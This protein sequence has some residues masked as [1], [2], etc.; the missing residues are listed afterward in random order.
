MLDQL[1]SD[2]APRER[3][4]FYRQRKLSQ[5]IDELRLIDD[6]YELARDRGDNLLAGERTATAFDHRA[7]LGDFIGA[8]YVYGNV[9]DV[10]QILDVNA[11]RF[12]SVR[13]FDRARDRALDAPLD[14]RELVDEQVGGRSGTDADPGVADNMLDR[15][16][17]GCQLLLDLG[18]RSPAL[19]SSALA[20]DRCRRLRTVRLRTRSTRKASDAD[21]SCGRRQRHRRPSRLRARFRSPNRRH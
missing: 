17:C 16:A 21:G 7:V 12:Q 9:V 2:I 8:V 10:I 18:H 14:F 5:D 11:M 6:A 3:Y 13:S 15:L 4:H 19:I 20:A 1:A